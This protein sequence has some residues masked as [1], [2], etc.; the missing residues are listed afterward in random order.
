[1]NPF[2]KDILTIEQLEKD[3]LCYLSV[4]QK[5]VKAS[6]FF[7][8]H[9]HE[10]NAKILGNYF[11]VEKDAFKAVR[12]DAAL[13]RQML[14]DKKKICFP[15]G[16]PADYT[17]NKN[18]LA[19]FQDYN[20]AYHQ[21]MFELSWIEAGCIALAL[22]TDDTTGS[23]Y[24]TGGFM[25]NEIFTRLTATFFPQKEV[26]TADIHNATALGAALVVARGFDTRSIKM[27]L[28]RVVPI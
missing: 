7:L 16:I 25:K 13:L 26:Y 20:H 11:G 4:D 1:M 19:Q 2:S 5:Q 22:D 24:I 10:V 23:I 3:C 27:D 28:E 15:N 6:R 18:A 17:L 21:L 12:T 9:I 8:G 14:A